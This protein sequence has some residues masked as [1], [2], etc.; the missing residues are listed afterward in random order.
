MQ[1]SMFAPVVFF[2]LPQPDIKSMQETCTKFF[3]ELASHDLI[4]HFG[5]IIQHKQRVK[6]LP[7]ARLVDLTSC[8]NWPKVSSNLT[9]LRTLSQRCNHTTEAKACVSN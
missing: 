2:C 4:A 1:V 5:N 8:L 7:V 9:V 6:H 3:P